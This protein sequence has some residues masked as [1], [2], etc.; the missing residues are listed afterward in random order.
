MSAKAEPK[1][2]PGI[3]YLADNIVARDNILGV[4]GARGAS[5]ARGLDIPPRGETI[6]FAG[7]GYQYLGETEALVSLMTRLDK[8]PL[9]CELPLKL[10]ALPRKAGIDAAGI[11]HRLARFGRRYSRNILGDAVRVLRALGVDFAYLAGDEPCCGAPLQNSGLKKEFSAKALSTH[12]RLREMGVKQIIGTVPSCTYALGELMPAV[13]PGWDI[14]VKH[15]VEV[16]AEAL[17]GKGA[18]Y[19]RPVKV[20]YHDPCQLGRYLGLTEAPRRILTSINNIELVEH[21]FTS[22]ERATCCGGGGGFEVVFPELAQILAE[23]RA[24]ELVATGADIIVTHCPGCIL[25][26]VEGLRRVGRA[27]IPVLD[28]AEIVRKSLEV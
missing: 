18:R 16:V 8:S 9:G 27:D 11:Y 15:F 14:G 5:W 28:I 1:I 23:N 17:P 4:S 12:Q 20:A 13:V 25:Q 6:F 26:L 21:V 3:A 24:A 2:A 19:P 22:G 10:A 7:C